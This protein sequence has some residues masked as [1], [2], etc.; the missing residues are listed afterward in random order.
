MRP[1]P[2]YLL[3]WI[4]FCFTMGQSSSGD[5]EQWTT[6]EITLAS[7]EEYK[8]PYTDVEVWAL[9]YDEQNREFKRPAFWDGGNIW[10]IR[11]APTTANTSWKWTSF[12]SNKNDA[13]LHGQTG[14]FRSVPHSGTNPLLKNGLLTMSKGHRSIVHHS[15]KPFLMVA[16]TPWAIPFRAT[17]EQVETYAKDRQKKGFNTVLLMT[18]QPDMKA[19]GPNKRNT[20]QGFKRAFNDLSEGSLNQMNV[21]YFQYYDKIINILIAHE[22]VPVHQPVFHGF[23]WKGLDVLGRTI[24]PKEYER[25]CK[26]LLARYGSLPA[27]WL[28]GGD[29]N[30]KDPGILESGEML[31]K[32]DCYAQPT[33]IHYNP[34]DDYLASWAK[35]GSD[36][37]FHYNKSHQAEEWLDFQWA[38][39]GH[40]G[41]HLYHKVERM[42]ANL[43]TKGSANGEPTY[44]GMDNGKKG[45]GWWQGE[46]A[47]MQ[48]MHGGTMGVAYGAATLWQWKISPTEEGWQAWTDQATSWKEAMQLEGAS[49]VGLVGKI[50]KDYDLTDIEKRF[51]LAEGKPLLAKEGELYIAYLNEGGSIKIPSVPLGLNY[52]WANPKTGEKMP[53][54]TVGDPIFTAPD[55]HPWVLIISK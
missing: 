15:G 8:N 32:W 31:E 41:E 2:F 53:T 27:I 17:T 49:H 52:H 16:D 14:I 51:D 18:L 24:D 4:P 21:D 55:A 25:Y 13:G 7:K 30:G 33:G 19:E 54:K 1:F 34:C 23:G 50:L 6:L 37:C 43:P 10:K 12:A 26:Y 48:L 29:H 42:Y 36:H 3:L 47:W 20:E 46:E 45:L 9:F 35:E 38:Q 40:N 44:E 39:T 22:I 5:V 11:F 28:L